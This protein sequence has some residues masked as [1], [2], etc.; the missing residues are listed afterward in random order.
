MKVPLR[1]PG[2]QGR[3]E[4]GATSANNLIVMVSFNEEMFLISICSSIY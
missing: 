2:R 1:E 3:E 4:F